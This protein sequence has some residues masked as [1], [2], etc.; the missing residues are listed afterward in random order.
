MEKLTQFKSSMDV[1]RALIVEQNIGTLPGEIF[2][3]DGFLRI[4]LSAPLD[5]LIDGC[6]RIKEFFDFQCKFIESEKRLKSG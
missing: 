6:N 4:V 1:F 2:N 5:I 3:F